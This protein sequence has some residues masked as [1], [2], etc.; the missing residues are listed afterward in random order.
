MDVAVSPKNLLHGQ[1][2]DV[3]LGSVVAQVV[4]QVGDNEIQSTITRRSAEQMKLKT[5]D[6]VTVGIKC[7]DVVINK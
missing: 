1:V 5:G 7:T 3:K 2:K 4:V 6:I